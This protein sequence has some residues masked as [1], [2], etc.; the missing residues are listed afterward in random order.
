MLYYAGIGSRMTPPDVLEKISQVLAPELASLG[1]C[2]RSGGADGADSAFEV[3][4][5]RVQGQKEIYL[6]WK[7][8]NK[9]TSN[10][11]QVTE[12]ALELAQRFHPA[13][14]RLNW[15]AQKLMA[16][17]GYQVLGLDLQTPVAFVVCYTSDGKASGGTGQALRIAKSLNISIF[18]LHDPLAID[19]CLEYAK[20]LTVPLTARQRLLS[21]L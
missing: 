9:S 4:A 17:N 13:W 15:A 11:Y 10:L 5:D 3:G 7:S 2:L 19:S 1:F 20:K 12:S 18:N 21:R 6:P 16:R 14:Q 8:F